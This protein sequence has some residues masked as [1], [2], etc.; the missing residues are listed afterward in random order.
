MS[1][2]I[3]IDLQQE[4]DQIADIRARLEHLETQLAAQKK[5]QQDAVTLVVFSGELDKLLAAFTV[6][7]AAG[8]CGMKVSM[9]FTFWGTAVLKQRTITTNKG[10]IERAFGMLLPGGLGRRSLSRLDLGGVG[11]KLIN[12][13][14]KRKNI[15]SLPELIDQ[16]ASLGVEIYVCQ[17]SM[18]LM[19]IREEE[20]ID[21]PDR[22]ICGAAKMLQLANASEST[23]FI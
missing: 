16:S 5:P 21:Y 2:T 22:K 6:A 13:E 12:V 17:M 14:M 11:R 15:S 4:P 23:L 7:T 20:L 10:W 19:G 9:F 8:A 3:P 1:A 18:D